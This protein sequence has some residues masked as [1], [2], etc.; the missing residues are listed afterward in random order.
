M[1]QFNII[2]RSQ[3]KTKP[4]HHSR[5]SISISS[6][7]LTAASRPSFSMLIPGNKNLI[8]EDSVHG[9]NSVEEIRGLPLI[10]NASSAA[11]SDP[12]LADLHI[13]L[14]AFDSL[15]TSTLLFDMQ[16]LSELICAL[17]QLTVGVLENIHTPTFST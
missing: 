7:T 8:I 13:L 10:S 16:S 15:F 9:T 17:A 14:E 5:L 11:T 3:N 6:Q 4:G 12:L 1:L 2:E